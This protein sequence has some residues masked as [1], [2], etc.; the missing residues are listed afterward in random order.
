MS[1]LSTRVNSG[2]IKSP[3]I[4]ANGQQT[5]DGVN[6]TSEWDAFGRLR[7]V[8]NRSTSALVVEYVY[9]GLNMQIGRHADPHHLDADGDVDST[10]KW[11]WTIFDP[12][13]RRDVH[14]R[15]RLRL[16]VV[17]GF[18]RRRR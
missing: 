14:G 17:R 4:N 6:S 18:D 3:A 5:D 15:G 12:R 16:P 9:N 7:K 10:D 1:P 13:W 2:V 8:K 11:E